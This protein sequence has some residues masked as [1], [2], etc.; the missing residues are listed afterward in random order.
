MFLH[1]DWVPPQT[2][3]LLVI[4]RLLPGQQFLVIGSHPRQ[5]LPSNSPSPSHPSPK[6]LGIF[7]SLDGDGK[8]QLEYMQKQAQEWVT[9]IKAGELPRQLTWLGIRSQLW[10]KVGYGI[11]CMTASFAQLSQALRKPYFN[12]LP[13]CG[14]NRNVHTKFRQLPSGFYGIG[15]PHPSIEAT[16]ASLNLL[17]QHY[18]SQSLLGLQLCASYEAMF[19]ELGLSTNPIQESYGKFA[20]L[21]TPSWL[22]AIWERC[23]LF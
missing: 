5:P 18:G 10:P 8:A 15:L 17:I 23:W 16:A 11:G 6:T 14:V 9:Q 20:D 21:C 1:I 13:S 12:L 4:P 19:L 22:R 7:T 3:R 2:R